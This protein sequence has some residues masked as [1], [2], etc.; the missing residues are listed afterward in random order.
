MKK[1]IL[2]INPGSKTI[3][4]E[5]RFF[6]P[7]IFAIIGRLTPPQYELIFIDENVDNLEEYVC[8]LVGITTTHNVNR[9]YEIATIFKDKSVPVILGGIHVSALPEEASAFCDSVVIGNVESVWQQVLAD[10]ENNSLEKFYIGDNKTYEFVEPATSFFA[11]KYFA[12]ALETSRGCNNNCSFCGIHVPFPQ[13]HKRKPIKI[14][15]EELK[16]TPK[17]FVFIIDNNFYGNDDEY[18]LCLFKEL[19]KHKIKKVFFAAVSVEFYKNIKLVKAAAKCGLRMV[20]VGFE[21]D[22]ELGLK[23]LNKKNVTNT[24]SIYEEYKQIIKQSHRYGILVS[25]KGIIGIETDT[26]E[27]I[28]KRLRFFKKLNIDEFSYA[29]LTPLPGT[30]LF[31]TLK[32][33]NRLLYLNFPADWIKY[34]H[35][36]NTFRHP[37]LSKEKLEEYIRIYS[38]PGVVK[39]IKSLFVTRSIKGLLLFYAYNYYF[40]GFQNRMLDTLLKRYLKT[41]GLLLP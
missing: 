39:M 24:K 33:E 5:F 9:A 26:E 37:N 3:C 29:I 36:T 8:D 4:S 13:P 23:Q 31:E 1:R 32:N 15:I 16:K 25:G 12:Y 20:F 27:I 41:K 6:P 14:I 22:S 18:L 40:I 2:I 19:Q 17:P 34:D 38:K 21:S 28:N 10:F 30:R 35:A 11:D 7:L